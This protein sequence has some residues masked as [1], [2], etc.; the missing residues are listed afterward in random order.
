MKNRILKLTLL[1]LASL[2]AVAA[3]AQNTEPLV[4]RQ[5]SN[6]PP[7]TPYLRAFVDFKDKLERSSNG[8]MQVQLNTNEPNE[9][10]LLSN[11]RRGRTDC[12]GVSLQGAATVVPEI[13]VLQ[14]PFLFENFQQVDYAYSQPQ[15]VKIFQ[16]LFADKGLTMLSF[17]EVG[18][19]NVYG[20]Q[21]IR[22]PADVAG[23]KLRATQSRASQNFIKASGA[24][25]VVLPIADL[26]PGLQTGLIRGG[27]S[28]AIVYDAIV[29]KS[30]PH[31]TLT[32]HAFDSGVFLCNRAWF[33]KLTPKQAEWVMAAWDSRALQLN[34]RAAVSK[35]LADAPNKGITVHKPTPTELATWRAVGEKSSAAVMESLPA[36]AA[37]LRAELQRVVRAAPK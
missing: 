7:G 4:L 22:T 14:L 9:A 13:A 5:G 3:H 21:P 28:G 16:S 32:Q 24:D 17:V 27:E 1:A 37:A 34:V 6:S 29:A 31:Y 8:A 15:L 33:D 19:T 20:V 2:A 18:F 35:I 30:A 10:N 26:L 25:A 11:L 36:Q 12:A 23:Q